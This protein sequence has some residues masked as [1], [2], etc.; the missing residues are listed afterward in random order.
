MPELV[1]IQ[2]LREGRVLLA[3][4]SSMPEAAEKYDEEA[5]WQHVGEA[6]AVLAATKRDQAIKAAE[7]LFYASPLAHYMI[8]QL[9]DFVV[10]EGFELTSDNR[11]A[12][13][14]LRDFWH[15]P[16]NVLP[17]NLYYMVQEF[18]VYGEL[19]FVT[20]V[21][22]DGFTA[23]TYVPPREISSVSQKAGLPG[24]PEKI[25]LN[26]GKEYSVISWDAK[27]A[28]LMGDCFYFRIQHLGSDVRGFPR[29]LPL[30]DFLRA[31]E[32][33]TY[34]YLTKRADWDA[35][36]W[37]VV[38]EGFTQD[39]IDEWLKSKYAKPPAPGSVF[40]S[41][42]RCTWNLVTPEFKGSAFDRDGSFVLSYLLGTG[43]LSGLSPVARQRLREQ[44]EILD[45][46]ARGLATRQF[47]IRSCFE[48]I[49]KFVLQEAIA[50]GKLAEGTYSV[51]CQAPRLG[52]RDFQ[53]AAG[54]LLRFVDA[55]GRAV[56]HQ[57]LD[58]AQAGLIFKD[59]LAR[60]G[61]TER[62]LALP[63]AEQTA[64]EL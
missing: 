54:A 56:D 58:T 18:F 35:I 41:N 24:I 39:Q 59:M 19:L 38:L 51:L 62:A 6:G 23:L 43:G 1:R 47:E 2:P 45:P 53:R 17:S 49:G 11:D 8:E 31:W 48:Y 13:T 30:V 33:F 9:T 27:N 10:G 37:K 44:G 50:A 40:A 36:W 28:K 3:A 55:L 16:V 21:H 46:V 34:N 52:V 4:A 57:W 29:L 25:V 63:A 14:I 12:A 20:K 64:G 15:S 60:L 22:N 26:S 5:I 42:E 32:A 7:T 61:M